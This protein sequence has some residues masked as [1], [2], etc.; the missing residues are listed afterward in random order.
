M[1]DL[2]NGM[3]VHCDTEEKAIKFLSECENQGCKWLSGYKSCECNHWNMNKENTCYIIEN[4][5]SKKNIFYIYYSDLNFFK[6]HNYHIINFEHLKFD[7]KYEQL[8]LF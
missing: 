8:S 4:C 1:I 6:E 5:K 3:V 2:R 7:N